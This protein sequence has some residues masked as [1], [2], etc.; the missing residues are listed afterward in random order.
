MRKLSTGRPGDGFFL[1]KRQLASAGGTSHLF[2]VYD[3][4]LAILVHQGSDPTLPY[5]TLGDAKERQSFPR[6][7][8]MCDSGA[9]KVSGTNGTS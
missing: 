4:R 2:R 5:Q 7:W 3:H 1:S 6:R 8:P 9:E